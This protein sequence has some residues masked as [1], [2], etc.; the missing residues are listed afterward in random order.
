M[1]EIGV[2]SRPWRPKSDTKLHHA[3]TKSL[4]KK[5]PEIAHGDSTRW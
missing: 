1:V 2:S 3:R 4:A 5:Q